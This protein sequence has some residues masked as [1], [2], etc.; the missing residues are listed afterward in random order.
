[1]DK[2]LPAFSACSLPHFS[3]CEPL[4]NLTGHKKT[5]RH[6]RIPAKH[7]GAGMRVHQTSRANN[8][9]LHA[10][11]LLN[12]LRDG[13]RNDDEESIEKKL[14]FNELAKNPTAVYDRIM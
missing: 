13:N 9:F 4:K 7:F 8:M 2:R 1:M 5:I 3:P 6:R 12:Q 14:T 10:R 11:L